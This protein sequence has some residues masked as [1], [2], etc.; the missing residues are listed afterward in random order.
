MK[1]KDEDAT[2]GFK[3]VDKR[4]FLD[5]EETL[6]YG[7]KQESSSGCSHGCSHDHEEENPLADNHGDT[8]ERPT[9]VDFSVFAH[10]FAHQAMMGLGMVP[11]FDSGLIKTDLNMAKESIDILEMLSEK[12]KNNL[13]KEEEELLQGML[14][15]LRMAFVDASGSKIASK[16]N[17]NNMF[18]SLL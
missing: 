17:E 2:S 4:R 13:T 14:Y 1:H 6:S 18:G 11:W 15:Q 5:E 12:T 16:D 9:K 3:V 8:N 10:F 7:D